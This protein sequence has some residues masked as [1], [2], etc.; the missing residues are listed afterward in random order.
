[1]TAKV[2][3][4]G[5]KLAAGSDPVTNETEKGLLMQSVNVGGMLILIVLAISLGS[6]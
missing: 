1:M 2:G 4:P 6:L 3:T 5:A